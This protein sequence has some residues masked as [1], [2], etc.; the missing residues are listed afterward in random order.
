MQ[1]HGALKTHGSETTH[2]LKVA[3]LAKKEEDPYSMNALAAEVALRVI[4]S[5]LDLRHI[6]GVSNYEADALSRLHAGKE[7]PAQLRHVERAK[8]P[9]CGAGFC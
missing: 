1:T 6:S 2:I 8:A 9:E 4:G 3:S 7:V 5:R